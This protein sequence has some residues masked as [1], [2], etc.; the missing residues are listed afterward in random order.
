MYWAFPP[1]GVMPLPVPQDALESIKSQKG[2]SFSERTWTF[3]AV[4]FSLSCVI[5]SY[6]WQSPMPLVAAFA[7]CAIVVAQFEED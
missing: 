4:F 6:I 1:G 5:S 2:L 3:S 7:F